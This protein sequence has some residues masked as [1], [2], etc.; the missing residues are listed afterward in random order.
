MK[1][2]LQGI[3][4]EEVGKEL[5]QRLD[6]GDLIL[7]AGSGLSRQ[8]VT[9]KGERPPLWKDLLKRMATWCH[10]QGYLDLE[11]KGEILELLNR[12]YL[13]D[14]G[15]EL[16]ECLDDANKLR[17]CLGECILCNEAKTGEAHDLI[18]R[19]AFRGFLTTNY[20]DFIEGAA[21]VQKGLRLDKFYEHTIE[22][23]LGAYREKRPFI[24]K[25]HGD[26]TEPNSIVLGS[27]AY[28]R[29]LYTNNSYCRCLDTIFATASVL[30]VGFGASDPNV[31]AITSRVA[32]FDGHTPR[33][34]MLLSAGSILPLKAKRLRKDKGIRVIQYQQ[35]EEHSG[36]ITFLKCL[37]AKRESEKQEIEQTSDTRPD[38]ARLERKMIVDPSLS[39]R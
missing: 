27:R 15:E 6:M 26:L 4:D 37:E 38:T 12:G 3:E 9:D 10:A 8:T 29:V 25:L 19:L 36:L 11:W 5:R 21:L 39:I 33:H 14:A 30:F 32:A 16:R 2:Y 31:E 35:D 23:V 34:W 24:V 1:M 20:D 13:I 7:F 22:G 18:G 28:E 17:Q